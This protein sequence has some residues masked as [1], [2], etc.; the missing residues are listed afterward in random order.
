M[1]KKYTFIAA[2]VA[3]VTMFGCK[4][5]KPTLNFYTWSDYIE[6]DNVKNFEKEFNCNVKIDTFDSNEF[7]YSKIK[8][9][10]TGYDI[11]LPTSYM[12][13]IMNKDGLLEQLDKSKLPNIAN[14]NSEFLENVSKDAKMEYSVPFLIGF[15]CIA[16]NK[17]K[18]PAPE[19]SWAIFAN[20]EYKNRMTMLDDVPE[21]MGA[22]LKYLGYSMNT[23]DDAQ[24]NEAKELLLKWKLNLAKFDNEVYKT[25]LASGEFYIV[26]GYSG[27]LFQVME[28]S[29]DLDFF[30]PKEGSSISSDDFVILKS[31]KNKD[32]AYAFINYMN[33]KEA[34]A[35]NMEYTYFSS[36]VLGAGELVSDE[37]KDHPGIKLDP[38]MYKTCEAI[39]ELG[40]DR[41]KYIK[42]WDEIKK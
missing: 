30:V 1:I 12:A 4:E 39:L 14:I 23:T 5:D 16:Y 10:A 17:T 6:M 29:D 36:P 41:N 7:M 32:L 8:S 37:L 21:T 33:S 40:E 35:L 27:D 15:T 19:E 42:A 13:E 25:G 24:I 31:S 3:F 38:Q 11:I 34:A 20:P 22:A 18:V 2:A 9:G 26:Q 28:D